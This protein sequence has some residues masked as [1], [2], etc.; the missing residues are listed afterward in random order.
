MGSWGGG[1]GRRAGAPPP[2]PP[3]PQTSFL[4]DGDCPNRVDAIALLQLMPGWTK[5]VEA[6]I[7]TALAGS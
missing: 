3:R 1:G 4:W 6:G 2:P 5:P 7:I